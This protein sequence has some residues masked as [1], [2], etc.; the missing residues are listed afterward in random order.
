HSFKHKGYWFHGKNR[1]RKTMELFAKLI[2]ENDTIFDIG[3]HI[4][5]VTIYF[6]SLAKGGKI[7]VFE[8]AY[9]NLPYLKYNVKSKENITI[10]E[11]GV[12][13][14]NGEL[15]LYIEHITGQNSSFIKD[16]Y[17]YLE[18]KKNAF[19]KEKEKI[20]EV[21]VKVVKLDDFIQQ[22][23]A[24]P[25]L[26]KI[27]AE[28]SE[29]EIIQ[30]MLNILEKT[31]P[32]LMIEIRYNHKKIYDIMKEKGYIIFDPTLKIINNYEQLFMNTF[33][34]HREAHFRLLSELKIL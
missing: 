26:L 3:G 9:S 1:E 29:Y 14:F 24:V 33:F 6:S 20:E 31:R 11:K 19:C 5:Y 2:R 34:L 12:W 17:P 23:N 4:G 25:N 15:K 32:I 30:G 13:N 22:V 8:P 16:F 21:L 10:I 28:G 7:Y 27:D 18:T